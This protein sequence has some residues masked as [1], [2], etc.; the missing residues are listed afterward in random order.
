MPQGDTLHVNTIVST[1]H[2]IRI[3]AILELKNPDKEPFNA[4]I[5]EFDFQTQYLYLKSEQN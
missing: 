5:L 3:R 2:V 4:F 1:H